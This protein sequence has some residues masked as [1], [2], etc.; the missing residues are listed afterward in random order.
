MEAINRARS[1]DSI[2]KVITCSFLMAAD[3]M[4]VWSNL[5]VIISN[6][7]HQLKVYWCSLACSS[8]AIICSLQ[9]TE[10]RSLVLRDGGSIYEPV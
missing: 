5:Q 2:L 3:D 1:V 7:I 6:K 10:I 8:K 4:T 9:S